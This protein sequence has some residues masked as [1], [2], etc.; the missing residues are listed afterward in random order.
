MPFDLVWQWKVKSRSMSLWPCILWVYLKFIWEVI[1]PFSSPHTFWPYFSFGQLFTWIITYSHEYITMTKQ[2]RADNT[3][4]S[5]STLWWWIMHP[6]SPLQ[7]Q[8]NARKPCIFTM[9]LY[10]DRSFPKSNSTRWTMLDAC[11]CLF[12]II[13]VWYTSWGLGEWFWSPF[14]TFNLLQLYLI[15]PLLNQY[16]NFTFTQSFKWIGAYNN[17]I[18]PKIY[19]NDLEQCSNQLQ[20]DHFTFGQPFL[21]K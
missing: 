3:L 11:S 5:V 6:Q 4:A 21:V 1:R 16:I 14:S 7:Y 19:E 20:L 10:T 17:Q 13:N 9:L 2:L 8:I 15:S 12:I 18:L